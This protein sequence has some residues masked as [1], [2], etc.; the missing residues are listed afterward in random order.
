MVISN[1][2]IRTFIMWANPQECR[3]RQRCYSK[4]GYVNYLKFGNIEKD[5]LEEIVELM[6]V[7][8]CQNLKGVMVKVDNSKYFDVAELLKPLMLEKKASLEYVEFFPSF[9][10]QVRASAIAQQSN[11]NFANAF[12]DSTPTNLKHITIDL[13]GIDQVQSI[14]LSPLRSLLKVKRVKVIADQMDANATVSFDQILNV[15][16]QS[17]EAL[18]LLVNLT[19]L[20]HLARPAPGL[21]ALETL[22]TL[23]LMVTKGGDDT[24][25]SGVQIGFNCLLSAFCQNVSKLTVHLATGKVVYYS[26]RANA[27]D[28]LVSS[29]FPGMIYS[30]I[31]WDQLNKVSKFKSKTFANQTFYKHLVCLSISGDLMLATIADAA[32]SS[33][34]SFNKIEFLAIGPGTS[35]VKTMDTINSTILRAFSGLKFL[36][37]APNLHRDKTLAQI[38]ISLKRN[39]SKLQTLQFKDWHV[40]RSAERCM[41]VFTKAI[42][43]VVTVKH[44][45]LR[46]FVVEDPV[47]YD[48]NVRKEWVKKARAKRLGV[49]IGHFH[50]MECRRAWVLYLRGFVV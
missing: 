49:V 41:K 4:V 35:N 7:R 15:M 37:F 5:K 9:Q 31:E 21:Y 8:A 13:S 42:D 44:P 25:D 28:A 6:T 3:W 33:K 14:D 29:D 23:D 39:C 19:A 27:V 34:S 10:N 11:Y 47:P 48:P 38:M 26:P 30:V 45:K 46:T 17:L 43:I 50:L 36:S 18:I 16:P 40:Q 1:S 20:Q 24:F 22:Q 32:K 12:L 2:N